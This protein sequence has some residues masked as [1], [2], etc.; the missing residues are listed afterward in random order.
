VNIPPRGVP[1]FI[2]GSHA[3]G[4]PTEESDV[5]LVI[6]VDQATKKLLTGL[7]DTKGIPVRFGKLN[8]V[9]PDTSEEFDDWK[10][11]TDI[12]KCQSRKEG[13]PISHNEAKDAFDPSLRKFYD[14]PLPPTYMG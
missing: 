2:T 11:T 10:K 8:L 13:R 12:L 4:A 9:M 1:S 7:S 3:Y 5:D 14:T 6:F